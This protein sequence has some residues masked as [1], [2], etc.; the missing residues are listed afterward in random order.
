MKTLKINTLDKGW[1]D[2]DE[3]LLHA[4][5]QVLVNF[6]EKESPDKIVDWNAN[7]LHKQAWKEIRSL[8]RWWT[9]TR[10]AHKSPFD[11]KKIKIPPFKLKKIPGT[12]RYEMIKPDREKYAEFYRSVAKEQKLEKKW[13]EEDQ[14]NLHRLI[15]IRGFLWT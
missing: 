2:Q 8:Y 10:P 13:H 11:E 14:R 7:D 6:M 4:A 3:M 5:F 12:D 15:E 9:E 1:H